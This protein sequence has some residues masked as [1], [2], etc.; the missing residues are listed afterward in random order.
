MTVYEISRPNNDVDFDQSHTILGTKTQR[1]LTQLT[2]D[3]LY[4]HVEPSLVQ[5]DTDERVFNSISASD[6]AESM[7]YRASDYLDNVYD[8]GNVSRLSRAA[9]PALVRDSA[10]INAIPGAFPTFHD[11][12][13][14]QN[15]STRSVYDRL[16]PDLSQNH[17]T[18]FLCKSPSQPNHESHFSRFTRTIAK[19][20][21]TNQ[22]CSFMSIPSKR[23]APRFSE[24]PEYPSV[25]D[26]SI[27]ADPEAEY[28]VVLSMYEV[29]NDRI[30]D[31]LTTNSMLGKQKRKAH[32]FK[33]TENSPDRKVVA[34]LRKVVCSTFAEA[35]LVLETGLLERRTS[36]TGS[37]ATSS[38]SHGFFCF[39][40]KK[41][42]HGQ[43]APGPWSSS[44]MTIVDLAGIW[45]CGK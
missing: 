2:L 8:N 35:L 16:Y 23:N 32:L 28:A 45:D 42:L 17:P 29:H 34:G 39:E 4:Q 20:T 7:I 13:K 10:P 25:D 41:R 14:T 6:V 44:T 26:V 31:L 12:E 37:N 3:A 22:E 40:V 11:H 43:G 9:T 36:G 18:Q 21:H 1:G 38:R 15:A 33:N 27:N 24:L 5:A 30:H 19:L